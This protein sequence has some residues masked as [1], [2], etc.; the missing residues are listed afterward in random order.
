MKRLSKGQLAFNSLLLF[1]P[2]A[3]VVE[4]MHGPATV[5]FACAC[6]AIIPLAGWI[7]HATDALAARTGAGI[8]GLLNATFGN[9]A[10]L[11]IAIS[12]L[13]RGLYDVVKASLTG[14]IIGNLLFILGMAAVVGG[15]RRQSLRFNRTAAGAGAAMLFLSVVSLGVPDLLHQLHPETTAQTMQ[16]LS[17]AISIVLIATYGL[18]LLFSLRTHA[19]LYAAEEIEKVEPHG[20]SVG[21]A[22]ALLAV[23]A[24]LTSWLSEIAVGS[25]EE[26]THA[27]GLRESFVGVV[28]LALVGNAAEHSTAVM[29]AYRDKMDISINIAIESSKQIALFVAPLLVLL[30]FFIAPHPMSL[31]FAPFEVAAVGISV[32]ITALIS[33]DGETNWLEGVQ[34]LAVYGI[35]ALAFFFGA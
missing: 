21:Q 32:A 14:S 15:A 17:V 9:A 18:G 29:L 35:L 7:G 27:L 25:V 20:M 10:E 6:I 33:L 11:I 16:T 3:L 26:A 28:V 8:G 1:M 2:I 31:E 5:R 12:G 30:S 24:A 23:A 4:L 19:H 13:R 34:L 22:V